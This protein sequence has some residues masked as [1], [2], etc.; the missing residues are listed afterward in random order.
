MRETLRT[1][2]AP[3]RSASRTVVFTQLRHPTQV[4]CDLPESFHHL[5][6][7]AALVGRRFRRQHG[8]RTRKAASVHRSP[9]ALALHNPV[10]DPQCHSSSYSHEPDEQY[11][12]FQVHR[13]SHQYLA[14]T[15]GFCDWL[16]VS[17]L[18]NQD[19]GIGSGKPAGLNRVT[20]GVQS[21]CS[22]AY[23]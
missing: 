1:Q 10:L 16:I 12:Y 19:P 6:L 2:L 21:N 13:K 5:H 18:R 8:V 17:K 15:S 3:S 22:M 7:A 4:S 9:G 23:R 20:C 14:C 11:G